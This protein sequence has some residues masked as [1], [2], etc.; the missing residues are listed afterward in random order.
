MVRASA[1]EQDGA[2]VMKLRQRY[3]RAAP[4]KSHLGKRGSGTDPV[5]GGGTTRTSGISLCLADFEREPAADRCV[6]CNKKLPTFL[7]MAAAKV[8]YKPT[9]LHAVSV[10]FQNEIARREFEAAWIRRTGSAPIDTIE[11]GIGFAGAN[12]DRA[13][14][15]ANEVPGAL[16]VST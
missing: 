11:S 1:W 8:E 5:C 6:R 13:A 2:I 16:A 14:D 12:A 15:I 10:I 4:V 7:R 9:V 3:G